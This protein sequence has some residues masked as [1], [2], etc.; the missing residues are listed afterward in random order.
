MNP[1][2]IVAVVVAAAT[3]IGVWRIRRRCLALYEDTEVPRRQLNL[4]ARRR[5]DLTARMSAEAANA[6]PADDPVAA[7][8]RADLDEVLTRLAA[9]EGVHAL[10]VTAYR[11]RVSPTLTRLLGLPRIP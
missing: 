4:L 1:L 11:S 8:V 7:C 3:L 5:D 10:A 6:A 9:V 2:T